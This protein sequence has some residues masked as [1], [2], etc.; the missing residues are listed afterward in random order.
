EYQVKI[1]GESA[2][3]LFLKFEYGIIQQEIQPPLKQMRTG[4]NAS[5][6]ICNEELELLIKTSNGKAVCLSESTAT[7]MMQRG[8]AD[9][10]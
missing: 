9:Y 5:D 2:K 8:W 10:F 3:S 1:T 6:V 7:I 4:I